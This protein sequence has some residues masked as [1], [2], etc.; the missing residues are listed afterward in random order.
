MKEEITR[1]FYKRNNTHIYCIFGKNILCFSVD[2]MGVDNFRTEMSAKH[3][4]RAVEEGNDV[5]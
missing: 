1:E 2:G 5:V 3:L 4:L